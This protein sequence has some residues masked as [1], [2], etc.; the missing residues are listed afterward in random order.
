MLLGFR[1]SQIRLW[2]TYVTRVRAS[3]EVNKVTTLISFMLAK[4]SLKCY[5]LYV[6][7]FDFTVI[8][9]CV[10]DLSLGQIRLWIVYLG[11]SRCQSIRKLLT[12][13]VRK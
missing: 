9:L 12:T 10:D 7:V 1:K 8:K 5:K 11:E 13:G 6:L 3:A 2:I 4:F